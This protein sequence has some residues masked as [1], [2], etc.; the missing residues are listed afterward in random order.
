MKWLQRANSDF[1]LEKTKINAVDQVLHAGN[2]KGKVYRRKLLNPKRL[3]GVGA[4]V[5]SYSIYSYL[6]YIAVSLGSTVPIVAACAAGL[7]GMLA[8][9]E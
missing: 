7:Y 9:T 5:A 3:K 8:F 2:L 1:I 4:F 6:P